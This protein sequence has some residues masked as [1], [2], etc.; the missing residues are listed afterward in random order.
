MDTLEQL[1]TI[2]TPIL[3]ALAGLVA[4]RVET[5]IK[6]MTHVE[7]ESYHREALH[8]ALSTGVK[9]A[10]AKALRDGQSVDA[11]IED[12]KAQGVAYARQSVPDAID[13]LKAQFDHL[14]T[15]A[16]SKVIDT[17]TKAA[18]ETVDADQGQ[19]AL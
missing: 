9:L 16:E 11:H 4:V 8:L 1:M 7:L 17:K 6:R 3:L 19:L 2:L 13:Y 15:M 14:L 18:P 12:I 5:R 10:V